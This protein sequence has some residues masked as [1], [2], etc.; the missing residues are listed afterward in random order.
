VHHSTPEMGWWGVAWRI[1]VLVGILA[2]FLTL[3]AFRSQRDTIVEILS[4]FCGRRSASL[5]SVLRTSSDAVFSRDELVMYDGADDSKP[6]YLALLG[7]VYDV[8][9]G[10]KHYAPDGG[11]GFFSG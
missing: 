1:S 3:P 8:S 9:S 7:S 4:T 11:Y 5:H 10:R 2:A 6:I